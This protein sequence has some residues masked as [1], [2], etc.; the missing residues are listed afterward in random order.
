MKDLRSAKSVVLTAVL[1][2]VLGMFMLT[3]CAG[4]GGGGS[5]D[6]YTLTLINNTADTLQFSIEDNGTKG[7]TLA[8]FTQGTW[9]VGAGGCFPYT[10]DFYSGA[11]LVSTLTGQV[12][13]SES[14][15]FA[16]SGK[17]NNNLG[18]QPSNAPFS[19]AIS[20]Q[21]VHTGRP[22]PMPIK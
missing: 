14:I 10:A 8:P 20:K 7:A 6:L 21:P 22:L 17:F 16:P 11:S 4:D 13:E 5:S 1:C 19:A 15:T 2:L 12:C 18:A 9:T 3:G